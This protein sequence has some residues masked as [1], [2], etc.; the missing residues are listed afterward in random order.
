MLYGRTLLF[1][2]SK[3]SSLHLVTRNSQSI[4]LPLPLGN[5]RTVLYMVEYYVQSLSCVQLF[6]ITWTV[7][8]QAFLSM[9]F[10]RQDYWNWLPFP[11]PGDLPNPGIEP[12]SLASLA[13]AGR[14]F[15]TAPPGKPAMEYQ[16]AIKKKKKRMECCHLQ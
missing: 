10:S 2:C 6:V 4:P 16:S 13:L 15:T 1:I 11:P 7:A 14:F 5:H 12:M 9:E 8:L 3:L